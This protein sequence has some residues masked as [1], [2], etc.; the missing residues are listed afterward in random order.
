M[1]D[2]ENYKNWL[3]N[4]L[5]EIKNALDFN[6]FDIEVYNEQDYAKNRS[7]KAKTITVIVK[8]LVDSKVFSAKTQPIQMLV[9]TEENGISVANSIL[10]KFCDTYNFAVI[11]DGTTYVKHMYSNPVVLTNFNLIG[12]GL[13]TVLYINT[14]LFILE[15]VMDITDLTVKISGVNSNNPIAIE[16]LSSTIGYTMQGDTQ[17]FG[18]GYAKTQKE[19]STFVMTINVACVKTDFTERVVKI[20]NETSAG[21]GN[22]NFVFNFYVGDLKFE[23]FT[24]KLTGA[25]ITTAVNNV[26]SLQ[27]SFSV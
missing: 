20:M 13:R 22:E 3:K 26:P 5:V 9:I 25:T 11:P 12:I 4:R 14:T 24:M 7:I 10:T 21:N 18:S 2:N 8:F 6:A 23:D 16:A 27:L 17:P 15:D 1:W 19:F